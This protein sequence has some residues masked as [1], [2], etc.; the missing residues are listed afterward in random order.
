MVP[1]FQCHSYSITDSLESITGQ[2]M[3]IYKLLQVPVPTRVFLTIIT[4]LVI[5]QL[6]HSQKQMGCI[7]NG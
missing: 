6:L 5:V 3:S 4:C 7:R 1:S 2:P